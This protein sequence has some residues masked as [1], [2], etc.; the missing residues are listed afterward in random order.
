MKGLSPALVQVDELGVLCDEGEAHAR[1]F[2]QAGAEAASLHV[3][4]MIDD[5]GLLNALAGLPAVQAVRRQAGH[6][7]GLQ[8]Q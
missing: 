2:D 5:Y 6:D 7:L 8:S 4:C 3:R 1:R